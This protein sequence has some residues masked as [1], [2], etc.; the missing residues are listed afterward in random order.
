MPEK[1]REFTVIDIIPRTEMTKRG[2]FVKVYEVTYQTKGGVVDTITIPED[3][4]SPEEVEKRIKEI[5]EKHN[6]IMGV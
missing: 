6:K 1:E 3:E 2:E 4:Y 5:A